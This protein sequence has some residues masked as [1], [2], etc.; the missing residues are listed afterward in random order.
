LLTCVAFDAP[1]NLLHPLP[2]NDGTAVQVE[3]LPIGP[4]HFRLTPWPFADRELE[5]A[6]PARHVAGKLFADS[7]SLEAAFHA[8]PVE[9]LTV[10]L[11]S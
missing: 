2:L 1:A 5:F 10:R 7:S 9:R 11:S 3:V 8:S 6:F 4:R